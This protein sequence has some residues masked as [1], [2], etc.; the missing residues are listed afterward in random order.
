ADCDDRDPSVHPG[1]IEPCIAMKDLNCDGRIGEGCIA[2][3]LD[4][5]GFERNDAV[6]SCPT[7]QNKHPGQ[8]DCNDYDAAVYPGQT[9]D[10][11]NLEAGS[12]LDRRKCL[13]R[14]SCRRVYQPLGANGAPNMAKILPPAAALS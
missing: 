3:D 9:S 1:A 5:D 10:C 8:F 12:G 7:P 4:G 14:G 2:C 13:L 11:G 6:N